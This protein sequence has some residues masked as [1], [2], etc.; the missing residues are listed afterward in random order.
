VTLAVASS[1]TP[2]AEK[3]PRVPS[4]L[5]R[6][7]QRI[8]RETV[9]DFDLSA[10]ELRILEDACREAD[11][12]ERI[13]EELGKLKSLTVAGSM[14][15]P[16]ITELAKEIRQ[17]R[18]TYSKLIRDLSLPDEDASSWDGMTT[19]Q[20]ARRAALVRWRKGG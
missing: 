5:G 9:R 1:S 15:Q 10:A 6:Q 3:M 18:L 2:R 17:H 7:A 20:R 11:L 4:G 8:W 16:V 19:S 13:E 14:G 12:V